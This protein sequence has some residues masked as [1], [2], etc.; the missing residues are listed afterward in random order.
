MSNKSAQDRL[1]EELE[2]LNLLREDDLALER[3][4]EALKIKDL[5]IREHKVGYEYE[6]MM[7]N[8]EEIARAPSVNFGRLSD[9][10]IEKMVL[11]NETYI[12]AARNPLAF[13]NEDFKKI[14]PFYKDNVILI[15]SKTGGGKSTAVANIIYRL[16]KTKSKATGK[17]HRVLLITNEEKNTDVY[18]RVCCL[19]KGTAYTNHSDFTDQQAKEFTDFIRLL[20]KSGKLTVIEDTHEGV[21]GWSRTPEGI[22]LL[23]DNLMRN[24]EIYDAVLID[25]Y[26]GISTSKIDPAMPSWQVQEKFANEMD[27]IKLIYPAPIVVMAQ[28]APLKDEDDSTPYDLRIRGR[29][30]ICEKATFVAEIVPDPRNLRSEWTVW[31]SRWTTSIGQ[32]FFSGYNRGMLVPYSIQFQKS[33]AAR[34]ERNLERDKEEMLGITSE[35]E[36]EKQNDS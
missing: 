30:S 22:S 29:K 25:Y 20:G 17:P 23:F 24:N 21:S 5:F 34:V 4:K 10:A 31:K 27:R 26:Q 9:E 7:K 8:Q 35:R 2:K 36:E 1:S 14:V 19:I 11:E 13:I 15:G 3:R 12:A 33:V 28:M 16:L 6:T 32:S 18:N